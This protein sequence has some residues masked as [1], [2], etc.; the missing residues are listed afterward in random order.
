MD[1]ITLSKIDEFFGI[2]FRIDYNTI[3]TFLLS[4]SELEKLAAEINGYIVNEYVERENQ[5][6]EVKI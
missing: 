5:T 2:S 1:K 3:R 4:L 6:R